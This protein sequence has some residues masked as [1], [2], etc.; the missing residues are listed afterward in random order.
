MRCAWVMRASAWVCGLVAVI[1]I[2]M[3]IAGP[4]HDSAANAMLAAVFLVLWVAAW[5]A[6][7]ILQGFS[8]LVY[9]VKYN[10]P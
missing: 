4:P 10:R 3:T 7:L 5:V 6:G 8:D 2:I 1:S 9:N